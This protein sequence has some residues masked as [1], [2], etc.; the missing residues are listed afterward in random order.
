[1][2]CFFN[3]K[4]SNKNP[5]V[6]GLPH[7]YCCTFFVLL[8][9]T[10]ILRVRNE[11]II[12]RENVCKMCERALSGTLVQGVIWIWFIIW[13]SGPPVQD[14][15][16]WG[17][18]RSARQ[19]EVEFTVGLI[20]CSKTIFLNFFSDKLVQICSSCNFILFFYQHPWQSSAVVVLCKRFIVKTLERHLVVSTCY[21]LYLLI[22]QGSQALLELVSFTVVSCNSKSI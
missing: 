5:S 18:C 8:L 2:F 20:F 14:R 12:E 16:G 13:L 10:L 9:Y 21:W 4:Q 15:R 1:M 6:S 17:G 3:V 11:C 19:S 22:D 7:F